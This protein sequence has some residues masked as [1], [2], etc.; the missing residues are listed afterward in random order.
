[1]ANEAETVEDWLQKLDGAS[2]LETHSTASK[3]GIFAK[4]GV[5]AILG[6]NALMLPFLLGSMRRR[7]IPFVTTSDAKSRSIFEQLSRHIEH[8]RTSP[9]KF[10]DVGSGDGRVV[11]AAK[12]FS[13]A[14]ESPFRFSHCVGVEVNSIL[15]GVSRC[16]NMW[17]I[18]R[19]WVGTR[20]SDQRSSTQVSVSFVRKDMWAYDVGKFDVVMVFGD[21]RLMPLFRDK[22]TKELRAG[23]FVVSNRFSI[24]GWTPV[25]SGDEFFIYRIKKPAVE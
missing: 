16:S 8:N 23:S 12:R 24:P 17:D 6:V 10:I 7:A 19:R 13:M 1:M 4:L 11:M 2:K 18:F 22:F 5:A 9:L 14:P 21:L 25:A 20:N 15:L 3:L